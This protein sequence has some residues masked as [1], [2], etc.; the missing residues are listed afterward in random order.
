MYYAKNYFYRCLA[1]YIHA[2]LQG[3]FFKKSP[4]ATFNLKMVAIK[5]ITEQK[6]NS[7]KREHISCCITKGIW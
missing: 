4:L 6:K 5:Q 2:G 7:H 1:K 3:K